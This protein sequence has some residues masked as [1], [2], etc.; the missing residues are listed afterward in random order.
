MSSLFQ[1]NLA[2]KK[3]TNLEIRRQLSPPLASSSRFSMERIYSTLRPM[4]NTDPDEMHGTQG[5]IS[6]LKR[7]LHMSEVKC[8]LSSDLLSIFRH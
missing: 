6:G 3:F 8:S 7:H 2:V 1:S 5:G 4:A